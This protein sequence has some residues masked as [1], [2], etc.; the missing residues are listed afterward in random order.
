MGDK[1]ELTGQTIKT[2]RLCYKM[3]ADQ[4]RKNIR[5]LKPQL[6]KMAGRKNYRALLP[7]QVDLIIKHL[8]EP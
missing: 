3:S 2:L 8:G 7:K 5:S 6:D 4:F 1:I